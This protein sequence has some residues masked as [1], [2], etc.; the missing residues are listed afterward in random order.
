[1][2]SGLPEAK[3]YGIGGL[4]DRSPSACCPHPPIQEPE[5]S[6]PRGRVS[7]SGKASSLGIYIA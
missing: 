1:M 7:I 3:E 5:T 4:V 2:I 6:N